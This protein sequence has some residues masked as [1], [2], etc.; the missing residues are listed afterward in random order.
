MPDTILGMQF[1]INLLSLRSAPNA[2]AHHQRGFSRDWGGKGYPE[3]R[4]VKPHGDRHRVIGAT[5]CRIPSLYPTSIYAAYAESSGDEPPPALH[6]QIQETHSSRLVRTRRPREELSEQGLLEPTVRR[7][8]TEVSPQSTSDLFPASA[9]EYELEES[10]NE[11]R[12]REGLARGEGP[13][14]G[15]PRSP[16]PR[17]VTS[18]CWQGPPGATEVPRVQGNASPGMTDL[19]GLPTPAE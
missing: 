18:P 4:R 7:G 11:E 8:G 1:C 13:G 19:E 12:Y 6:Q 3:D 16:P 9:D 10:A 2:G 15:P 14:A 17:S 5:S